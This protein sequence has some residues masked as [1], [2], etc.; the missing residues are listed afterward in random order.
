ML[1]TTGHVLATSAIQFTKPPRWLDILH[2][3]ELVWMSGSNERE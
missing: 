1:D 2:L 3:L